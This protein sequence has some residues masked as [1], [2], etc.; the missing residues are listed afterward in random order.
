MNILKL[1]NISYRYKDAKKDEY[2]LKNIDYEFCTGKLYVP[3]PC[4]AK[5]DRELYRIG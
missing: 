4:T 2:V 3:I 5:G 1:E